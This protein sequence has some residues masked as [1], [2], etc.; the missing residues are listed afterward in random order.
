VLKYAA[1]PKKVG[2]T[3]CCFTAA[4]EREIK[5]TWSILFPAQ[6]EMEVK[7]TTAF[8]TCHSFTVACT[9]FEIER[10]EKILCYGRVAIARIACI[11]RK[12]DNTYFKKLSFCSHKNV[13]AKISSLFLAIPFVGS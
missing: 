7:C 6:R 1:W 3:F 2:C 5:N 10:A 9:L 4:E 13:K 11:M 8:F 12:I